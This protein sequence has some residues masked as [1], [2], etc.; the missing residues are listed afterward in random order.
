M[1]L[2]KTG[3]GISN[4]TGGFGG[5]YFTRDNS[6]L[7]QTAKPRRV[8]QGTP[9]QVKQRNAFMKARTFCKDDRCVSYN[10]YRALNNLP[11][12]QPPLDYQIP[13]LKI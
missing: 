2:I 1:T 3:L 12:Q 6:G 4:I 7:H 9:A 10:I 8:R 5:V 11:L 13:K